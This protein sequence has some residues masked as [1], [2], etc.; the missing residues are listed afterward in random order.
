MIKLVWLVAE[1]R[2]HVDE[3]DRTYDSVK[4]PNEME[5]FYLP[6]VKNTCSSA[7]QK[8]LTGILFLIEW[9]LKLLSKS[10]NNYL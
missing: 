4:L 5:V 8:N 6:K 3:E 7:T 2:K 1:V 10:Y 9:C